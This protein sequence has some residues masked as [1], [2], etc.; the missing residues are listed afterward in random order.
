LHDAAYASS[1]GQVNQNQD[2]EEDKNS[3]KSLEDFQKKYKSRMDL[4]SS[5]AEPLP[6]LQAGIRS[7]EPEPV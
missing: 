4:Q 7:E 2:A 6:L 5:I 3:D 1:D